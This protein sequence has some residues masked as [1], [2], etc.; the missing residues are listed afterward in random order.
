MEACMDFLDRI[1]PDI[2]LKILTYLEDSS[3]L[4]RASSVSRSWR[5]FVIVNGLWKQLCLRMFPQLS[6]VSH[7]FELNKLST[8][9]LVEAG[10][11]YSKEWESLERDDRAY[12]LLARACTSFIVR[13]CI[14]EA[15][16]A[17]STDNY[18]E[19]SID[20]TL[21]PADIVARRAS[22]W[23][24]RG[25]SN[26]AVT[27]RLTYKLADEFCV[28]TEINIRPF[29]A[30]FQSGSPLYLVKAM[31]FR[32]GHPKS[33]MGVGS[34]LLSD[35]YPVSADEKFIW[36]YTSQ[37]FPVAQESCLQKYKLPEPVLCVGGILQIEL[38]GRVQRLETGGSLSTR[39]S[40]VQ[41]MGRP[42]SPTFGVEILEP[43]GKF[44]L[45]IKNNTLVEFQTQPSI[46]SADHLQ[47]RR[48][49]FQ[50]ILSIPTILQG[51]LVDDINEF[52]MS[53][54]EE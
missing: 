21:Q 10:S 54:D 49:Y 31:R 24:T 44:V 2:S 36:T 50:H 40:Y 13:D 38:R 11:S 28:I 5:H 37:E 34:D 52:E 22:Y 42:L 35:S 33:P 45:K 39:M 12:A 7:V 46:P 47:R 9:E 27:E 26:P 41:V 19:E 4:L 29:Q 18:P 8:K 48:T 15:I 30:Y 51:N 23:L 53:D 1:D 43:S 14:L 25:Q 17:S 16:S 3:D 6:R 32:M 20:N